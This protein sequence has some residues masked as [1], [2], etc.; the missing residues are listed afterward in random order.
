MRYFIDFS[1]NGANYH[2]YQIQPKNITIQEV[3]EDR[4]SKLLRQKIKIFGAGRTDAGVNAKQMIAHFDF[5]FD[6]D[7]KDLIK[8]LNGFL[9]DDIAIHHI[10]PVKNDAHAR[11]DA[12]KR[13]YEYQINLKK[14]PFE[15][16]S[17]WNIFFRDLNVCDMN[18]A[19]LH[20][21]GTKDFSS[22]AKLHTDVKTHICTVNQAIW[23]QDNDVLI[24][25]ISADR[26]LRNMVRAIVGTL[27]EVGQGVKSIDDFK[28]IIDKKNRN[29][30]GVSAP[31]QGLYLI[32]VEY[33]EEIY[34]ER[35]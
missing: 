20:L 4:M 10:L 25:T 12:V 30:A 3:I 8:K 9:P 24:F 11:F 16:Y 19:A 2:G 1:Y 34:D 21:L 23:R 35:K 28:K 15:F 17:G 26:F 27:V 22:F 6:F 32:K 7:D 29:A 31:A 5:D 13:T 18:Q 33:P 14:N